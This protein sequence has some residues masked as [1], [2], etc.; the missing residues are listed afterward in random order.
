MPHTV[1]LVSQ[2]ES[3]TAN[4]DEPVL[5][6]AK[7]QGLN[8]PHSCQS[9]ICGQCKARLVSGKTGVWQPHFEMALNEEEEKN[10]YILL[11]CSIAES[12]LAIEMPT[13]AGAG[14]LPVKTV[15]S[16]VS[17]IEYLANT[18]IV[19]LDLPKTAPF[20]FYAGQYI[21]VLLK[22]GVTRS[23]SL[24]GDPEHPE[25][26]ELH[27]RNHLG[28][29]F[30][31]MLFGDSP[32]II[33]KS[34]LRIRGPLGNAIPQDSDKPLIIL[35]TGTGFA[36]VQSLLQQ[37][38]RQNSMRRIHLYWG[39]RYLSDLYRLQQAE[40]WIKRLPN[41]SLT[42]VLSRPHEGWSGATGYVQ[43]HAVA[44]YPDM[45]QACVYAC[46]SAAMVETAYDLLCTHHRLRPEYFFSDAFTPAGN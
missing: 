5:S 40:D 38:A 13:Y 6:A 16:R 28:G 30:S 3:F 12:D 24:A 2:Q 18:A 7:Q 36:P 32:Q 29:V 43:T 22:G 41:A 35:A 39:G 37:L 42:P 20:S 33:E 4:S 19:S 21:D 26:L 11:C 17:K 45:S 8:L 31:S 34:I 44:D 9:G 27:V 10:G 46:G 15:P 1:T 25:Q 23:Y 14:I